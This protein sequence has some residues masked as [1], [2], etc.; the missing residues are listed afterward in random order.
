M[1]N[2]FTGVYPCYEN[3]FGVGE[4]GGNTAPGTLIS[5]C[6]TFSV[7]ING[8]IVEWSPFEEEG[9]LRRKMTGKDIVITVTAKRDVGDE[10]NDMVA[11]CAFSTMGNAELDFV[12]RFPEGGKVWFKNAVI[13]VT[14][15]GTGDSRDLGKLEFTVSSNGK[16]TFVPAA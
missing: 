2:A 16:P 9:W 14:N 8:N 10:G 13:S 1:A 7:A 3:Q 12:W 11:E 4:A 15:C 6:E 5:N